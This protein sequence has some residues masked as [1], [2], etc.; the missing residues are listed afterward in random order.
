MSEEELMELLEELL[1]SVRRAYLPTDRSLIGEEDWEQ[2]E[3]IGKRS[4]ETLGAIF[5]FREEVNL[6]YL[7]QPDKEL[8]ILEDLE[9]TA[10]KFWSSQSGTQGSSK[11]SVA[12]KDLEQ[13][14]DELDRLASDSEDERKPASWPFIKLIRYVTPT[15]VTKER[16]KRRILLTDSGYS[17][18]LDLPILKK[19]LVLTDL[20]GEPSSSPQS[21]F[22]CQI[23]AKILQG[24][25]T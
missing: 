22:D 23:C 20:P 19:G 11:F 14:K 17:V 2:Y 13:C 18:F 25:A 15:Y 7:V 21:V 16:Q 4:Y 6:E 12:A 1:R 24:C 9:Q 10:R 5:K 3:A 8:E